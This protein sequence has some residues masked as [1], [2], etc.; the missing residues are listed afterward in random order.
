MNRFLIAL[1]LG[2][3]L[4]GGIYLSTSLFGGPPALES[5]RI[6]DTPRGIPEFELQSTQDE[7]AANED[8][9]GHWTLLF[10]GYT[11]CPDIC[12]TTMSLLKSNMPALMEATDLPIEVWMI[13]VDPKRDHLEQVARYV[14]FFGDGFVG[15]RAEHPELYPFVT[16]IGMMYSVPEEEQEI[17]EVNHSAAIVLV[18][19]NGQQ[20]AIFQPVQRPGEYYTIEPETFVSD[21]QKIVGASGF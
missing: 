14:N 1:V 21:F 8:L 13:S 9:Q 20:H 2:A 3:A 10:T 7:V 4:V 19:P 6:Y 15:V 5:A 18:N 17:Y 16:S 11:Y 12:P